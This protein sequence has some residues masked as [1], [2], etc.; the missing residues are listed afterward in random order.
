[1]ESARFGGIDTPYTHKFELIYDAF[2]RIGTEAA[3]GSAR[4]VCALALAKGGDVLFEARG[5]VEGEIA[6]RPT[7]RRRVR[8]RPDF[9]LSAVQMHAG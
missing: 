4:F 8:L 7:R 5:V 1:M 6:P 3:G 2:R 9:F